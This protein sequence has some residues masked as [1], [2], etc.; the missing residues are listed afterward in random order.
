MREFYLSTVGLFGDLSF[1]AAIIDDGYY[2]V[3]QMLQPF[4]IALED[5]L[6]A[7]PFWWRAARELNPAATRPIHHDPRLTRTAKQHNL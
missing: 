5:E 4:P 3:F 2:S 6:S 1:V 7:E